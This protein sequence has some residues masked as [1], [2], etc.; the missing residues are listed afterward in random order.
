MCYLMD[1]LFSSLFSFLWLV[2]NR[3]GDGGSFLN[4]LFLMSIYF[5][6]LMKIALAFTRSREDDVGVCLKLSMKLSTKLEAKI[7]R[8]N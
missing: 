3:N 2:Q 7:V 5:K 6:S 4:T 1:I 8:N